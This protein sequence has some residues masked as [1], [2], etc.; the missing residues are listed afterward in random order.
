MKIEIIIIKIRTYLHLYISY[1]MWSSS[2]FAML[3]VSKTTSPQK[4]FDYDNWLRNAVCAL[5][6]EE[7]TEMKK[8][9]DKD[10]TST[11]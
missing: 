1:K 11:P 6:L 7:S 2:L 10:T 5:S 4:L 9:K 3:K 8:K